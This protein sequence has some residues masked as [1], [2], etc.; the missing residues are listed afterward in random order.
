MTRLS[1]YSTLTLLL[2]IQA[3]SSGEEPVSPEPNSLGMQFVTLPESRDE[4]CIHETRVSDFTSFAREN[5]DVGTAWKAVIYRG[6][7]QA[8]NH[9]V[10]YVNWH[11][12]VAFCDWL[13]SR[14]G[15]SYRLPSDAEYS[16]LLGLEKEE[17]E[18]PEEKGRVAGKSFPWGVDFE[19]PDR[20][21]NFSSTEASVSFGWK[22][23]A[24]FSDGA[25]FSAPVMSYRP[26]EH[27]VFD[28]SGNAEEWTSDFYDL[29]ELTY[30][31]RGASWLNNSETA[32]R[33]A[34]R[35]FEEPDK[36]SKSIGFRVVRVAK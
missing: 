2:I 11:D 23:I 32:L 29:S 33:S 31:V 20:F 21:G 15:R 7:T 27:G 10:I 5:P 22:S 6:E 14:E 1:F 19:V 28:I 8:P 25:A 3:V 16:A 30:A 35:N 12:A 36:R 13:G 18:T 24:A 26:S 4:I 9:P 17:G 34:F